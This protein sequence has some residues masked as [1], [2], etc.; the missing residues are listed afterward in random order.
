MTA[1]LNER[2]LDKT[3]SALWLFALTTAYLMLFNPMTEANSYSILAPALGI[4]AA[5]FLFADDR[6]LRPYGW[7]IAVMTLTMG[8]LPNLVR[9]V[10]GNYFALLWHPLMTFGFIIVL[11]CFVEMKPKSA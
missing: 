3:N 1:A 2:R 4:W 5:L 8:L 11:V 10:F 6:K 9:P 7:L